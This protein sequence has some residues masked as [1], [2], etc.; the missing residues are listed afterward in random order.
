VVHPA[1]LLDTPVRLIGHAHAAYRIRE[2][3]VGRLGSAMM[4]SFVS[5]LVT[6]VIVGFVFHSGSG[7]IAGNFH[8]AAASGRWKLIS[9]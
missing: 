6:G 9:L 2:W 8:Y 7:K 3:L 4:A 5:V 1:H